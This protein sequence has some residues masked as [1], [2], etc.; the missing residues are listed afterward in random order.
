MIL[1]FY[2]RRK[3]TLILLNI[4]ISIAEYYSNTTS[5]AN[6]IHL[7]TTLFSHIR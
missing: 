3:I 4:I 2:K 6:S 1:G 5:I 7:I